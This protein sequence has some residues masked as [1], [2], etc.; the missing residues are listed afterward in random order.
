MAL[1]SRI[2]CTM[3]WHGQ[4]VTDEP[5]LSSRPP[6]RTVTL[7]NSVLLHCPNLLLD[8]T[9][10]GLSAGHLPTAATRP[11]PCS[12]FTWRSESI[13]AR[14]SR[15]WCHEPSRLRR[16]H[17]SSSC[18][19][20]PVGLR[21]QPIELELPRHHVT[22]RREEAGVKGHSALALRTM[23][24]PGMRPLP[25]GLR[26]PAV[27]HCIVKDGPTLPGGPTVGQRPSTRVRCAVRRDQDPRL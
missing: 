17:S 2:R 23:E 11:T 10:K 9:S 22:I 12:G 19:V 21:R 26:Q 13:W 5:S 20:R 27:R 4:S 1:P 25:I 6:H 24:F 8:S 14:V 18:L 15:S 7:S 3:G 16:Q